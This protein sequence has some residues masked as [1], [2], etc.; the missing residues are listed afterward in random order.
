MNN[1]TN[2][3][4]IKIILYPFISYLYSW[5]LISI[6]LFLFHNVIEYNTCLVLCDSA[7]NSTDQFFM[8]DSDKSNNRNNDS[9]SLFSDSSSYTQVYCSNILDKYKN[10]GKRKVYWFIAQKG[11][12]NY[13]NYEEFKKSWNPN[14]NVISELKKQLKSEIEISTR[15][16]SVTKRSLSW[17]LR[18][19]KP[20]GGRGL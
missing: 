16:L 9:N 6:V 17:F 3:D 8:D 19:S 18:G 13:P 10:I 4:K 11:K 20:G 5:L 7:G 2:F 1:N 14:M 12:G 15:K